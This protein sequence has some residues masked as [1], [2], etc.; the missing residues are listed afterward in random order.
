MRKI[1]S[2]LLIL[3]MLTAL[4]FTAVQAEEEEEDISL[5]DYLY[6]PSPAPDP[7]ATPSPAPTPVPTPTPQLEAD[8]SMFVTI[9][10]VGDVT[11]G[12]NVQHSGTSIF[13]K[14][15]KKQDNDINFIFRNVKEI[16]EEDDL[17]IAN[18]EGVLADDYKIPSSKRENSYLFLG[19]PSYAKALSGNSVEAVTMENNHVGDFGD[20]GIA[21]TIAAM[22]AEGIVWSNK[23]N[24]GVYETK[25]LKIGMLAYQTLNQPISSE[26]LK[27]VVADDIADARKICD[28]VIVSFHWGNELDYAPRSNQ[29]M[30]GRAAID[31]GAD[32]VLGHHS[33]RINPIEEYKGKYIVYSLANCSFAGNNKPSDMFTFIFQCRFQMKNGQVMGNSF[34]IIPCRISSR[35]DY[36][37]FAITPLTEQANIST[38][39]ST[40]EKNGRNLNY[41]VSDYPLEWE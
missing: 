33:H 15:L 5:W 2:V 39:L 40:L 32:L 3:A 29:L 13:E 26:E 23:G 7:N 9:T 18:F 22:E 28:L 16:F 10:A 12:R 24:L 38:V 37:D 27:Y 8:G 34:R 6:T 1:W 14:E 4:C 41:A 35:K 19:D 11:I 36:N 21:D 30:L 20:Q 25:G 17:T 31:S